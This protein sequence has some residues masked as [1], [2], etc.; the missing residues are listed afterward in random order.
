[1]H[2]HRSVKFSYNVDIVTL[3]RSSITSASE[4]KTTCHRRRT[5]S[6]TNA[7]G[8][9]PLICVTVA[10]LALSHQP[11]IS[12]RFVDLRRKPRKPPARKRLLGNQSKP[13]GRARRHLHFPPRR[14]CANCKRVSLACKR[15]LSNWFILMS[16][17][18]SQPDFISPLSE[19]NGSCQT[20][21]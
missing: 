3:L 14:L 20:L 18:M 4:E 5:S 12:R 2:I 16:T 10:F 8:L 13:A 6:L 15:R 17:F 11:F 9:I 7:A 19:A 1:M 21:V